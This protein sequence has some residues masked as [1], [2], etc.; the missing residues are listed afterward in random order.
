VVELEVLVLNR[1]R[2]RKVNPSSLQRF[3]LSLIRE[4]PPGGADEMALCLVSDRRMKEYNRQFR[5][6]NEPT[7]VLSFPGDGAADAE[8]RVHLGD[9]VI[10][11]SSAARQARLERHSLARELKILALHGYL[12]LLGYDHERDKG[13]M[14]RLQ[15]KV[16]RQLLPRARRAG[17]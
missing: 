15:R 4:V 17:R 12:H 3:M 8:G 5:G 2:Q 1:Q 14:I 11:V 13:R 16:A 10:S 7:D 9:I 6:R